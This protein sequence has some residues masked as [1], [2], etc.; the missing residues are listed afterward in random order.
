[1]T[2]CRTRDLA[3]HTRRRRAIAKSKTAM[4]ASALASPSGEPANAQPPRGLAK[5]A[6]APFP[7]AIGAH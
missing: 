3:S 7:F 4:I 6:A 2:R 1:V 5:Q